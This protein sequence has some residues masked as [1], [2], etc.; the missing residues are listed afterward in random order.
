MNR[1]GSP[2]SVAFEHGDRFAP[3]AEARIPERKRAQT[4][5][6]PQ[7]RTIAW[8][9]ERLHRVIPTCALLLVAFD[10]LLYAAAPVAHWRF[11]VEDSFVENVTF[12]AFLLAGGYMLASLKARDGR[13]WYALLAA[14]CLLVAGEEVSWG[15]RLFEIPTPPELWSLNRQHELNLHNIA[16]VHEHVKSVGLTL[17]LAFTVVLPALYRFSAA[18]RRRIDAWRIP[19]VRLDSSELIVLA[20]ALMVAPRLMIHDNPFDE[21]G[22]MILGLAF[23]LIAFDRQ[24][25]KS[26]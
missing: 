26:V 10:I 1:S 25:L 21:I 18:A 22:E 14:G 12:F 17:I 3:R 13:M 6:A 9:E 5:P 20:A 19:L 2:H 15:Q 8:P 4:D 16:G 24:G 11:N 7:F 23:M